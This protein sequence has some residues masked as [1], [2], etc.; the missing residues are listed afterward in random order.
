[1]DGYYYDNP[2][3]DPNRDKSNEDLMSMSN[4]QGASPSNKASLALKKGGQS[5][6]SKK[7]EKSGSN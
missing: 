2:H 6:L 1:M 7:S 4:S 5:A 3:K